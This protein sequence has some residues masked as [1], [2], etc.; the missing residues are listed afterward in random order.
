MSC[1]ITLSMK[2]SGAKRIL[3]E[4][5]SQYKESRNNARIPERICVEWIGGEGGGVGEEG[6]RV[7]WDRLAEQ[8]V[9]K[10]RRTQ[11]LFFW[12]VLSAKWCALDLLML[13]VAN[14]FIVV[15][16]FTNLVQSAASWRP[17]VKGNHDPGIHLRAPRS[18]YTHD[19]SPPYNVFNTKS[20]DTHGA[21]Q[22]KPL[23]QTQMWMLYGFTCRHIYIYMYTQYI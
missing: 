12:G 9:A 4:V 15:V 13:L 17:T 20:H 22:K 19:W 6:Y 14:G 2:R 3:E 10:V 5:F 1:N 16:F 23:T 18:L 8:C 11:H 7:G 21:K